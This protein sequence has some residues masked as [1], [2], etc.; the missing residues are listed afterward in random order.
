MS[1]KYLNRS[2]GFDSISEHPDKITMSNL[3]D[4]MLASKLFA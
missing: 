1:P 3:H 4:K 2:H